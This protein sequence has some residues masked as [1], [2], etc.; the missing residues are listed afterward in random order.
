V[1]TRRRA[2]TAVGV[3]FC[4]NGALYANVVP[5]L[6]DIKAELHLSKT[7]LGLALAAYPAGSLIVGLLGGVLVGRFGSRRVAPVTACAVGVNLALIGLAPTLAVLTG[8]FFVAGSLD[9]IADVANNAHGLRVERLYGRSILNSLHALWSVGAVAGAAMGTAAIG[10]GWPVS[11]HLALAG[12]VLGVLGVACGPSL[13][14]GRDDVGA[15]GQTHA[16]SALPVRHVGLV[17][18]AL[19]LIA[20]T[21]QLLEDAAAN[22][23]ALYLR[24]DLG[25]SAAAG[26]AAFVALQGMQMVGRLVGDPAVSRLGDRAVARFGSALACV[27]V[28]SALSVP[29][30]AGTVVAFGI[31]GFGIGTLIPSS[32]RAADAL[33]GLRPG[34][35]IA[36]AATVNRVVTLLA[37]AGIGLVADASSLRVALL[38]MPLAAAVTFLLA[39][40]L[41]RRGP[42]SPR[43]SSA[44]VP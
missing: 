3:L 21:G 26:G 40:V 43:L 19:G 35:G 23:S 18:V 7:A 31:A 44:D 20:A 32:V 28:A 17:V 4:V 1:T 16:R 36:L 30:I 22:W 42:V 39:G 2:R 38:V 13:L 8:V 6:P 12:M 29:G 25:A 15:A 14:P 41:P 5:R 24:E 11:T 27:A 33:P 9:A 10:L 37:P 34:T